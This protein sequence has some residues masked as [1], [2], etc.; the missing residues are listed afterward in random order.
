MELNNTIIIVFSVVDGCD[1][2]TKFRWFLREI[3]VLC[4]QRFEL[5]V[6]DVT[7]GYIFT[8]LLISIALMSNFN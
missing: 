3:V 4:L 6:Y 1:S 2:K 5:K 7:S 8:F